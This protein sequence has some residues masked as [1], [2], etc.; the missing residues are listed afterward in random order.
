L[1]PNDSIDQ[2]PLRSDAGSMRFCNAGGAALDARTPA[3]DDRPRRVC[4]ACA[5]VHYRNPLPVVGCVIERG[6]EILLC[7]RAIEPAYGRWTP[8]AGFL[9]VGE[10]LL[11]G[12]RRESLEEAG[13]DVEI[14]APLAYLDLPHIGQTHA[15]FR[16]R[17][18]SP[19]V[20]AGRES[21]E[22]GFVRAAEIPWN[23]LAFPVVSFA[24]RLL[25]DDHAQATSHVHHA[26]LEW[27]GMGSRY[28]AARYRLVDHLRL[29]L[30][31]RS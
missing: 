20:K 27:D 11:A 17:L 15:L 6:D 30:G 31:R 19:E 26:V 5:R 2:R 23:E 8:P 22:V 29:P 1:N 21:L 25:L 14:T 12:A 24:L 4:T 10:G 16:A 3:D 28:D 9:E 18:R 13:A 7:R